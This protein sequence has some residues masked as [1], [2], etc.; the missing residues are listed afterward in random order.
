[1]LAVII[2]LLLVTFFDTAGTLVGLAQ[3]AGL[4]KNDNDASDRSGFDG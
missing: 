4:M 2:V 3:Q 1:M